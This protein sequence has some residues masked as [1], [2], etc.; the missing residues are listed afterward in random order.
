MCGNQ[1]KSYKTHKARDDKPYQEIKQA[2]EPDPQM[3][4]MLELSDRDCELL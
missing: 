1:L 2:T 3:T 4:Q